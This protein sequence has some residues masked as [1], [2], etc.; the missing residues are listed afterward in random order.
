MHTKQFGALHIFILAALLVSSIL[1]GLTVLFFLDRALLAQTLS[2]RGAT[3][4]SG[5]PTRST[6]TGGTTIFEVLP[7]NADIPAGVLPDADILKGR[8]IDPSQARA[9]LRNAPGKAVQNAVRAK[10][11]K[12]VSLDKIEKARSKALSSD[13]QR[14]ISEA[15]KRRDEVDLSKIRDKLGQ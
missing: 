6:N 1:I 10:T 4:A 12:N 15:L 7:T 8:N 2:Q 3:G 14:K 5:A 11:G 9:V 13:G